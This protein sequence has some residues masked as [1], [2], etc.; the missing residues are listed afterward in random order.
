MY[1]LFDTSSK[2]A[3]YKLNYM[4]IFNWGTFD[5]EV[6]R[7]NPTLN[8]S[9]LTGAN[10]SGKTTYIDALLTLLVP[11]KRF[12]FY[13]QSS[14]TEKKAGRNEESYVLGHYGNIQEEGQKNVQKLRDTNTY[15]VLLCTFSNTNESQITIFQTFWFSG[16]SLKKTFG[17]AHKH[18]EIQKDFYPF[19]TKGEWKKRLA[20]LQFRNKN[21]VEFFD[22][23]G[24]Y[25]ERMVEIFGM[26]SKNALS[27]FNQIVGLKVLGNLDDFIRTNMLELL[28]SEEEY[29]N[30]KDSYEQLTAAGENID[31]AKK[32][33]EQLV[34]ID[35]LATKITDINLKI[36]NAETLRDTAVFWFAE[37]GEELTTTEL[38]ATLENKEN[39]EK[40]LTNIDEQ[41]LELQDKITD[42]EVQIKSDAVGRQIEDIKK[43][44]KNLENKKS[45][46]ENKLKE[47][48]TL[49]AE[50]NYE[51]NPDEI[52]FNELRERAKQDKKQQNQLEVELTEKVRSL[53]NQEDNLKIKIDEGIETI[54]ALQKNKINIRKETLDVRQ[55]LSD[56]LDIEISQLPFVGELVKVKESEKEWEAVI[57]KLLHNFALRMLVPMKYLPKVT[58]Y[59]NQNNLHWILVYQPYR[60]TAALK[61]FQKMPHNSLLSKLEFNKKSEFSEWVEEKITSEYA[62]ICTTDLAE[63]E[64]LP[65]IIT[66]NGLIKS[67]G[68]RY[69][70]DDRPKTLSRE[71]F[72]LGWDSKEK[73]DWW[74][75][76]VRKLQISREENLKK[77]SAKENALKKTKTLIEKFGDLY[78]NFQKFDEINWE[79]YAHEIDEKTKQKEKLE[80]ANNKIK[81]LEEQ[82]SKVKEQIETSK[83]ERDTKFEQVVNLRNKV[84]ELQ[85]QINQHKVILAEIPRNF[86]KQ[87]LYNQLLSEYQNLETIDFVNFKKQQSDFQRSIAVKQTSLKTAKHSAESDLAKKMYAFKNPDENVTK[88][89]DWRSETR[90][91][92]E[93]VEFV[94]E[95][96]KLLEKLQKDN[97]PEFQRKFNALIAD[98]VTQGVFHYKTFFDE[99]ESDIRENISELNKSLENIN[100]KTAPEKTYLQLQN[101]V[102]RN[103]EISAFKQLLNDAIP[104]FARFTSIEQKRNHYDNF[105]KPLM[106]KLEDTDWRKSVTDVR[107]WFKYYATEHYKET[108]AQMSSYEEMDTLSGGEKAQLTYTVLG[109]AIHY[110][111]GLTF[112]GRES[113]SFRFIAVDESF[114]NQD[115]DKATFLLDLCEQLN[116]Q[117]LVVTPS[118]KIHIVEP[119][120]SY[121][122]FVERK[123]NRNS[124]LFDMPIKQFQE[125][126]ANF[127]TQ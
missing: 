91:L 96:Q 26:R 104:D 13:N 85:N 102:K 100:Y 22:S 59:V 115:D 127:I 57:E 120:I 86:D 48:N 12:R 121:V 50:L 78:K 63:I 19:D 61:N 41:Q 88:Y 108:K 98:T 89:R 119:K 1:N 103:N 72:V 40:E 55:K 74:K 35:E 33:E 54:K 16:N 21:V 113:K 46:R 37:K 97:L 30:L 90:T 56:E 39:Q 82:L 42:L 14:G 24:N 80:A 84:K 73:I 31:K 44:I 25:A 15:S 45:V 58:E 71:N 51:Q 18:L 112:L 9:L 118:D 105:I 47:F 34:V 87:E 3:G 93:N 11:E 95:Y 10:G 101:P 124:I 28:D 67:N 36:R 7:I 38:S 123:N 6:F 64:R 23:P 114:S 62:Y 83:K 116:L 27:L 111:F 43:E 17:I 94:S 66:S 52:L 92:S 2:T 126:R 76:E 125:N 60:P 77:L 110:Q 79:I 49:A 29:R 122:H 117:L 70:K 4:E 20:K 65:K 32:Q 69:T 75:I 109:S 99:W 53:K 107:A 68:E 81:A 5:S 106:K 8:N